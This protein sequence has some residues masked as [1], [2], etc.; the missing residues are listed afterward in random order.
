MCFR[1]CSVLLEGNSFHWSLQ[2]IDFHLYWFWCFLVFTLFQPFYLYYFP[3]FNFSLYF[4]LF[5]INAQSKSYLTCL[6]SIFLIQFF[7][8]HKLF[9]ITHKLWCV[10]ASFPRFKSFRASPETFYFVCDLL[11]CVLLYIWIFVCFP[12]VLLL[13]SSA[14]FCSERADRMLPP[15]GRV[16]RRIMRRNLPVK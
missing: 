10:V 15:C 7:F 9:A 8:Y 1:F 4:F 5:P 12:A 3:H 11:R 6:R 2:R 14:H 13:D 16:M